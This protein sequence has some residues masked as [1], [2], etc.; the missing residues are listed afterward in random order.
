MIFAKIFQDYI[1][2]NFVAQFDYY[3]SYIYST[4]F[5]LQNVNLNCR[6]L[7]KRY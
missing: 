4:N 3:Y 6:N 2:L 5:K 1:I 7:I